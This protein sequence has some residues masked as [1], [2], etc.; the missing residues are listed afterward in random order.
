MEISIV[1]N[2]RTMK[3]NDTITQA[4]IDDLVMGVLDGEVITFEDGRE[5]SINQFVQ[6][7]DFIF[8]CQSQVTKFLC[9]NTAILEQIENTM[10]ERIQEDLR[11]AFDDYEIKIVGDNNE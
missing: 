11:D 6:N 7:G 3:I 5:I 10:K 1:K 4:Q 9:G 8:Y 2:P